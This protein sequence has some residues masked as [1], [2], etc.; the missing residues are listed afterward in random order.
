MVTIKGISDGQQITPLEE[1]PQK[2]YKVLI[3]LLEEVDELEEERIFSSNLKA[4]EFW[5]NPKE[6]LYQDYLTGK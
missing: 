6:D 4:F 3:T 1:L 5:N 2:K